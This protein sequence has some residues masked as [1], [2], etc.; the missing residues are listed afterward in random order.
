MERDEKSP[1]K[2]Q[3]SGSEKESDD[4]PLSISSVQTTY[5]KIMETKK[6]NNDMRE[7]LRKVKEVFK[8]N[9]NISSSLTETLDGM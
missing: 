6:K 9:K 7:G 1:R 5:E 2:R 3:I 4:N 8:K